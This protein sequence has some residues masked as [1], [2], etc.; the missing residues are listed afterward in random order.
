MEN[1][2]QLP[3]RPEKIEI[4]PEQKR[5]AEFDLLK[6]IAMSYVVF[7]HVL[8]RIITGLT[9]TR[10]FGFFY[11]VHMSMFM[12]VSG[13]FVKRVEKFK[14]L[15]LYLLKMLLYYIFPAILFTIITV[16]TIER[17]NAHDLVYWLNEFLLRTDTFYWYTIVAYF[18]NASLAIGFYIANK[19]FKTGTFK[20]ELLNSLLSLV[21][22]S[23]LLLP[24]VY[25]YLYKDPALLATNQ[26]IYLAPMAFVGFAFKSF[27]P[28]FSKLKNKIKLPIEIAM[29]VLAL[30]GYIV[31][32]YYFPNWLSMPT[33]DSLIYHML[34]SLA[35]VFAYYYFCKLITKLN[36]FKKLS[37]FGKYSLQLYLVHV[38]LLRS[39]TQ[40]VAKVTVFDVY[41]ITFI[42]SYILVIWLGS[43]AVTMLLSKSKYTDILLFG[44][45]RRFKE[46]KKI[47]H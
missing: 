31:S 29:F 22:A 18:I 11:S 36:I 3:E 33:T 20:K 45:Y 27:L 13:Y 44:N 41:G 37:T 14:D 46:F 39:I 9:S 35:G 15:I 42:I 40:Y 4:K 5:L 43:L 38:L 28:Y 21:F 7:S 25:I 32:M 34:G 26:L 19:L 6:F 47:K 8:Q 16:F 30:S 10:Y 24:F 12:F 17:Y 1:T 2:I 23:I